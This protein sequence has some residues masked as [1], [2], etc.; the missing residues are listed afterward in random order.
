MS[1]ARAATILIVDD[2]Q[3]NRRLLELLL[4]PEGYVTRTAMNGEE[5]LADIAVCAPDLILLDVMMPGMNGY[6]IAGILKSD[7]ATANIPIIMVTAQIERSAR[8]AGL[9]AG[10]EEFLTKPVDRAELWVRV[11]NL[12]R[13]KEYGDFLANHN[14]LLEEQVRER[15]SQLEE[16]YRDTVFTLVRAAEHKDEETGHH[17]RRISYYCR[18]LAEAMGQPAAFYEA[19]YQA[20]PMHDIG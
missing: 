20:S 4:A 5:A 2:E 13:L 7:P 17:V 3:R 8:L 9:N 11:R 14:R 10:A 6:Q 15:T 12:L 16:A 19:I 1:A 18:M